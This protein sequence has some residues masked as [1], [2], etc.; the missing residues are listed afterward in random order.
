MIL[1]NNG[2]FNS[3]IMEINETEF[4]NLAKLISPSFKYCLPKSTSK[5][6]IF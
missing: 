1:F 5:H 6:F 3:S 4:K 2:F